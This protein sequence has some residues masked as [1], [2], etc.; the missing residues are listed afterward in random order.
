MELNRPVILFLS[1]GLLVVN[2]SPVFSAT[3]RNT[4]NDPTG[5][6]CINGTLKTTTASQ[7]KKSSGIFYPGRQKSKATQECRPKPEV[8]YCCENGE[9]R[10]RT[11]SQCRNVDGIYYSSDEAS[12]AKKKC[13]TEKGYC[14]INATLYR[15][16]KN[17]CDGKG[18]RYYSPQQKAEAQKECGETTQDGYCCVKGKLRSSKKIVCLN[19]FK[20]MYFTGKSEAVRTC[21]PLEKKGYCCI[22]G[23]L[24][25]KIED[26]CARLKGSF[27]PAGERLAARNFCRADTGYCCIN[28]KINQ[29]NKQRCEKLNGKFFTK[30]QR[31]QAMSECR[32]A[33]QSS[34]KTH[35]PDPSH[36]NQ[37]TADRIQSIKSDSA[38]PGNP[39]KARKAR[40]GTVRQDQYVPGQILVSFDGSLHVAGLIK[41]LVGL[42]DLNLLETFELK[43]LQQ[44]IA[45][46]HTDND[47]ENVIDVLE[48]S[49]G[50]MSVQQNFIFTT[51]GEPMSKMQNVSKVLDLDT[52]HRRYRGRNMRVAVIDTGVDRS[53][54]ELRDRVVFHKNYLQNSP[55]K[56]ELHG[57]AVAGIIGASINQT[58]IQGIAPESD[59]FALRACRQIAP[60]NPAGECYSSTIIQALDTAVVQR[61]HVVSLCLGGSSSDHLVSSLIEAGAQKNIIFVAPAGNQ[62]DQKKLVF[63]ASHRD[64]VAVAGYNG[65]GEEL[66]NRLVA[67]QS[68]VKAPA[69]HV[70]TTIPNNK[71]NF[72]D[73]TSMASAVVTGLL[74]IA[75]EKNGFLPRKKIFYSSQRLDKYRTLILNDSTH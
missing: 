14:C 1:L 7:C 73:G 69:S 39:D 3:L 48:K 40:Q 12:R 8:G 45:L 9:L 66:P 4:N 38:E 50:V 53:H 42:Y 6:C 46:F 10:R 65:K 29:I 47:L 61:V 30:K 2:S 36:E 34:I 31:F 5:Y 35:Q 32:V 67:A 13:Q 26:Q 19:K 51:M 49:A 41:E 17:R 15:K 21:R 56:P 68:N 43:S 57:T 60:N 63:P 70:L 33:A 74:I 20:G 11:R 16:T 59:L 23:I 28:F 27:F 44:N 72:L 75:R 52:I 54:R 22:D 18:G 24:K 62:V 58:G 25:T 55:Y 37:V 64:V 71:Y